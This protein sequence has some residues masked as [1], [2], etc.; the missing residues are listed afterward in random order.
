M[1]Y[2]YPTPPYPKAKKTVNK[3][4]K[5]IM[6]PREPRPITLMSNQKQNKG[7]GS[8]PRGEMAEGSARSVQSRMYLYRH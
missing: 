6:A 3:S 7:G 8:E 2:S 4:T 1:E 5:Q